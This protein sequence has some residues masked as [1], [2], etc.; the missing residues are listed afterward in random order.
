MGMDP[1]L[2]DRFREGRDAKGWT[3]KV[4]AE[5][6]GVSERTIQ[7]I[8]AGER[9]KRDTYTIRRIAKEL[10]IDLDDPQQTRREGIA[11]APPIPT[12]APSSLSERSR[13]SGMVYWCA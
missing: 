1:S 4:L 11:S 9:K 10:G 2:G 7:R 12:E 8:E 6:V 3:Q 5:K 13:L